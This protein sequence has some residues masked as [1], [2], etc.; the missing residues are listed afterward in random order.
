MAEPSNVDLAKMIEQL[1]GFVATLQSELTA[2]KRDK[3]K[4]SAA[5]GAVF[6]TAST[7]TIGHPNF[8]RSTFPASMAR[9]IH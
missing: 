9:P 2:L 3:E 6:L 5:V 1:I 4:S 7:T 8:R